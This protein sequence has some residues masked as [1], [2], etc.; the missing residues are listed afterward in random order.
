MQAAECSERVGASGLPGLHGRR[1]EEGEAEEVVYVL[2][3]VLERVLC[4]ESRYQ[5]YA[6]ARWCVYVAPVR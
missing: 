6:R 3:P 5:V 1:R 4:L 2:L